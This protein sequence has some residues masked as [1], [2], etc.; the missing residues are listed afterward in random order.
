MANSVTISEIVMWTH[1]LKSGNVKLE[2]ETNSSLDLDPKGYRTGS[3]LCS[4]QQSR[5][6]NQTMIQPV[7]NEN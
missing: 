2:T 5:Q 3:L 4:S 6:L 1:E 7:F